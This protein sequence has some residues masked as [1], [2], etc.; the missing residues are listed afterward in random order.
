MTTTDFELCFKAMGGPNRI[1]LSGLSTARAA[2][3]ADLGRLEVRRIEQ[4]YS[5]YTEGSLL[6]K[7]NQAAGSQ[8]IE[9]DTETIGLLNFADALFKQSRG[10]FDITSG[11]LR[12]AWNFNSGKPPTAADLAPL[13]KLVGWS[14]V[15]MKSNGEQTSIKLNRH[16]MEIDFGGFG[17]EYAADRAAFVMAAAGATRGFVDLGGDLRMIGPQGNGNPWMIGIQ[18]PRELAST[19]ASIPIES[20]GLAT[21]GD[22]ERYFEADGKRYCHVLNPKTG[23]PVSYWRSVTVIAPSAIAAGGFCTTA[24]LLERD[25]LSTLR[26]SNLPFLAMNHLGKI[27]RSKD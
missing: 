8:A 24:M 20:G 27:F 22:Y 2:E 5:R 7:I 18:H 25:G 14:Q 17:K 3:I 16:G 21:S 11:V 4:K 19:I 13:L 26:E 15:V 23:W 9:I 1:T 12:K 10:L 6:A